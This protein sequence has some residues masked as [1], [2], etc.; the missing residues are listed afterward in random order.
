MTAFSRMLIGAICISFSAPLVRFTELAP[1]TSG[2]YRMAFGALTLL[3]WLGI[4]GKIRL[5]ALRH[6]PILLVIAFSFTADLWFWHQSIIRIGP[7]LS[8]ILANLQ[9]FVMAVVGIMVYREKLDLRFA[10]GLLLA[11][12][13]LW[14]VLAPEWT[15]FS[16]D[17]KVGIWLGIATAVAYSAY[18]LSLR[19]F[20]ERHD[21]QDARLILLWSSVCVAAML[22]VIGVAEQVD[23]RIHSLPDFSAM[24]AYGVLCQVLGWVLIA[25][26]MAHLRT[27]TV[28]L[29]LLLQP[30]LSFVWDVLFFGR[31]TALSEWIGITVVLLGIYLALT[32]KPAPA[33]PDT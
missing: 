5:P 26:S 33:P 15:G 23:F 7:G 29:L 3:L 30:A 20:Q 14:W 2:F 8:T 12:G 19:R 6:M 28:G 27:S 16:A 25:S 22:A 11:F 17:Y 24:L 21:L 31:P 9:V 10:V 4:R 1:T 32:R 18:I 13:G